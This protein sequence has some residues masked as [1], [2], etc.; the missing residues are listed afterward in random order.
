[1]QRINSSQH[2]VVHCKSSESTES[3]HN[4]LLKCCHRV[5]L[6]SQAFKRETADLAQK[7]LAQSLLS[8]IL[9]CFVA[10]LTALAQV[11]PGRG[12]VQSVA[13]AFQCLYCRSLDWHGSVL[14]DTWVKLLLL[15]QQQY[16]GT[17]SCWT[18]VY[19]LLLSLIRHL[20]V[21]YWE[22]GPQGTPGEALL[23]ESAAAFCCAVFSS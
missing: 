10:K 4:N 9:S 19:L 7:R 1:M 13:Q 17:S 16:A 12:G 8:K 6:M 3:N 14:H 20:I 15:A 2:C 18:S 11:G 23:P 22:L 21:K 5:L